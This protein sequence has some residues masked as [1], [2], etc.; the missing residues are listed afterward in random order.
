MVLEVGLSLAGDLL[1][2]SAG[3]SVWLREFYQREGA[4]DALY[5]KPGTNKIW[6]ESKTNRFVP[7]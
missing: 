7:A 2:L 6:N 4:F 3:Q 1:V 5:M